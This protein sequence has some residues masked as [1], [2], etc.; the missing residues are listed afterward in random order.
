MKIATWNV[1]GIRARAAQFCEWLER[2]RPDVV[3]LQEL[4]ADA[5]QVP[6]AVRASGLSRLLARLER[7]RLFGCFH[8]I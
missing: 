5:T 2:D 1:N 8:C 6:P 4:K 3:C 7:A